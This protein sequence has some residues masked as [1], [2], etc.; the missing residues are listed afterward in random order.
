MAINFREE[1]TQGFVPIHTQWQFWALF[2]QV[3]G[4]MQYLDRLDDFCLRSGL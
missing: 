4:S 1:V 3:T 2:G